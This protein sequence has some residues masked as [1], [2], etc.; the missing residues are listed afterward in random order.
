[1]GD[2]IHLLIA[3]NEIMDRDRKTNTLKRFFGSRLFLFMAL[4]VLVLT[5]LGLARSFYTGYKIDQEIVALEAEIRSL[6]KKKL[7]SMAILKYVMSDEFVEAK[8]RTE[9]NLKRP[10]EKVVVIK[11]QGSAEPQMVPAE[12]DRQRLSNPIKWWYYFTRRAIP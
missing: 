3:Y 7:E 1:M 10:A 8:A 2:E 5:S 4:A 9:L 6:D 12:T 11:N